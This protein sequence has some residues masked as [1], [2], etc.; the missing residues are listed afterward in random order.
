MAAEVSA[1]N[2]KSNVKVD[3]LEII[4]NQ[5][6]NAELYNHGYTTENTIAAHIVGGIT[7]AN[8]IAKLYTYN[9]LL[10]ASIGDPSSYA[11]AY[12]G[13][14]VKLKILHI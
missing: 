7:E 2:A 12:P 5:Y 13:V 1:L 6:S 4:T 8:V 11:T 3:T 9:G 14:R 10:L